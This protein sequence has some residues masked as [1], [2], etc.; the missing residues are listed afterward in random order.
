[1]RDSDERDPASEALQ[2]ARDEA[3][4]FRAENERLRELLGMPQP[5]EASEAAP[6]YTLFPL[7][8]SLPQVNESAPLEDKIGLRDGA[9][10][11]GGAEAKASLA[12]K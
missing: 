6:A 1:M 4:R 12:N 11:A 3:E 8:G 2:A 10:A 9:R 7:A 5:G